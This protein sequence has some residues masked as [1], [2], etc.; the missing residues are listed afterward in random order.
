[1]KR[2]NKQHDLLK[3]VLLFAIV[4]LCNIISK[5]VFYRFDLTSEKRYTLAP[6]TKTLL[7]NVDDIIYVKVYL[8]GE[9]PAGF[10]RLRNETQLL[11][12]EFRASANDNIEYEF[13]NPSASTDKTERENVYR[14]LY[15]KGL[16]PTNLE[17][18]EENGKSEQII[19]PAAMVTYKGREMPWQLLKNQIG[20][21]PEMVLNNS[22]QSLEYEFASTIRKLNVPLKPRIAFTEGHGELDT[23]A[24]GDIVKSL[25]EYYDVERVALNENLASLMDRDSSG[26]GVYTVRPKYKAIVVAKPDSAFSDKDKFVLDQFVMNGGKVLWLL[27]M[28]Y[29]NLDS[30]S[31][32]NTMGLNNGMNLEDLLFKYGVRINPNLVQDMQSSAILVNKALVGNQP[33]WEM[34]PWIFN[35]LSL[36]STNHP[37]VKN[38]DVIKFEFASTIDT[39]TN[40]EIR[41]SILLTTSKYARTV[42]TP[43]RISLAM[44][45]I[46]PDERKFRNAFLP[47]AVLLE[48]QFESVYKNR[49][50]AA[51]K[52]SKEIAFK[53]S[54]KENKMI[55]VADGDVIKNVVQRS[56]GNIYPLGYDLT[57]RQTYGNK[58]FVLNC[59]DYLCDDSGLLTVRSREVT[60][61]L[62]DKKKVKTQRMQ[63]QI[64]NTAFP[65]MLVLV[66]GVVLYFIRRNKFAK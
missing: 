39:L 19:F 56:T 11:L 29:T 32:G 30:L 58:N 59:I 3:L 63:W 26:N 9:F 48:G 8:E 7:Q 64:V 34:E 25:K 40:K 21:P 38:L 49:L 15:E 61:R 57:T 28:V 5:Y 35:P 17:V 6:A 60:L 45:N 23:L 44:V 66:V 4:V 52:Q 13:V 31:R 51:I 33:R 37:I 53:E 42:N 43:T 27:D 24:V 65:V 14:Q 10:K 50:T 41:K 12:E 62:M 46:K 1:M 16:M 22:I 54:S 36:P 2:K 18:N 20:V 55:V 47:M